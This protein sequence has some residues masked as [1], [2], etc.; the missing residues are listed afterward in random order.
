MIAAVLAVLAFVLVVA[1]VALVSVPSA[2]VV[3]GLLVG[4]LA[5]AVAYDARRKE[6]VRT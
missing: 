5:Y 2:L 4:C 3:A 6:G 1:G